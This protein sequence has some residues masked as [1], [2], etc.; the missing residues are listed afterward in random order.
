VSQ[1]TRG[2]G[3]NGMTD[4]YEVIRQGREE[5]ARE[6]KRN[7]LARELRAGRKRRVEVGERALAL[8]WE[9]ERIIGRLLKLIKSL[10]DA[11]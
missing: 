10:R 4:P 8:K 6:V 2:L 1:E 5:M 9:L 11:D 3:A 7:R